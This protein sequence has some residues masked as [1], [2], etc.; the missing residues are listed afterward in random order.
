M[1][2]RTSWRSCACLFLHEID[3]FNKE[4]RYWTTENFPQARAIAKRIAAKLKAL[5]LDD[6][7]SQ[8]AQLIVES[9]D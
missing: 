8:V 4:N 3:F 9:T 6:S 1:D 2:T 5:K 7:E